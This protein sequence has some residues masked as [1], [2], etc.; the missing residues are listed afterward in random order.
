MQVGPPQAAHGCRTVNPV[1]GTAVLFSNDFR[2]PS[3][4]ARST[5]VNGLRA[6]TIVNVFHGSPG[7]A[8]FV[9]Q[10][11]RFD[12]STAE[13]EIVAPGKDPDTALAEGR[14]VLATVHRVPT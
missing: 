13:I 1:P 14:R 3:G 11:T 2:P 6:K 7:Y 5:V 4:T 12:G 10:F 8:P 9:T